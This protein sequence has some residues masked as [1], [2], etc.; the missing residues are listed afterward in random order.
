[1]CNVK[2]ADNTMGFTTDHSIITVSAALHS[3][4]RGPGYWKHDN[5]FLSDL[6]YVNQ[7]R[8]TIKKV[9]DEYVNDNSV[10]PT[11]MW[12]MIKLKIREQSVKY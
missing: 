2:R 5:S 11:L 4:Q 7:I 9:N 8:M 6:N 10:N 1:M 12:E 3:N